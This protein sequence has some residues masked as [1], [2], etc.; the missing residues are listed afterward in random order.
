MFKKIKRDFLILNMT[1]I[2]ILMILVCIY[3]YVSMRYNMLSQINKEMYQVEQSYKSYYS[4]ARLKS[5]ITQSPEEMEEEFLFIVDVASDNSVNYINSNN[6][7]D[8]ELI[9]ELT[10]IC[11]GIDNDKG[12][13]KYE[14]RYYFFSKL[15]FEDF[16]TRL[17]VLDVSDKMFVLHQL[18]L[19]LILIGTVSLVLIF[20]MSNFFTNKSMKPIEIAFDKQKH[21]ISDASHELKTPLAVVKTNLDVLNK[22]ENLDVDDKKWLTYATEEV[23]QMSKMVNEFLYLAKM[24]SAGKIANETIIDFSSIING[25]IL[26]ME[27]IAFEKHIIINENIKDDVF[28]RGSQDGIKRL[29]VILVD[30]AIKYCNENGEIDII[31][32]TNGNNGSFVIKNTGTVIDAKDKDVIFEKFYRANKERERQS[33]SYGIGLS[34]AKSTCENHGFTIKAY[35]ENDRTCFKIAFKTL[36]NNEKNKGQKT[37]IS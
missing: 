9:Q 6:F 31:L 25:V 8:V 4:I 19:N 18:L 12:I 2:S 32:E 26:T 17:I 36:V 16:A 22:S 10:H 14:D 23:D 5:A 1:I 24:D 30:N 13:V 34:I 20:L 15:Y 37:K 3:I 35:P 7:E 33:H 11:M 27:A 29:I 21:F 28:I